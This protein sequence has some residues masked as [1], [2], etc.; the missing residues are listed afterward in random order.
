[1]HED[2]NRIST[3]ALEIAINEMTD[4][5]G[6]NELDEAYDNA[7]EALLAVYNSKVAQFENY[8]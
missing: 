1:M 5:K 8:A 6:V 4:A 3:F 7:R 2:V